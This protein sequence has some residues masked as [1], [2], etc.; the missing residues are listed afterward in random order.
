MLAVGAV[1]A[2]VAGLVY[3][4]EEFVFLAMAVAV[5]LAVGAVSAWHRQRV[6]R[7]GL[8]LVMRVPVAEVGGNQAAV[9]ELTVTNV[10]TGRQPP[11]L[12]EASRG[13]WSVSH[14]GLQESSF[15]GAR[16]S[17]GSGPGAHRQG[18]GSE[19]WLGGGESRPSRRQRAQ[20]RRAVSVARRLPD[21]RPGA[22]VTLSISVPTTRRGLLTLS[23]IG[24]WCEDPFRLVARR[25]TV[26]P[27]A[28]VIVF[29]TPADVTAGRAT[30][31]HPGGHE[32][33]STTGAANALSGDELNGLRP[34]APGDRLTRLHWPSMAR[35][36]DLVVRDFVEPEAGSLSLLVDLRPS[37]H[38]ADSFEPTIARAA[39]YGVRALRTGLTVE[40]CTSTGD[41]VVIA[42]GAAGHQAMLRA[43]ALLGPASPPAAVA[44]RWGNRPTGGA[45]WATA[46]AQGADVV[47]V[48][49]PTGAA[50]RPRPEWLRG[51]AETVL[52]P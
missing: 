34:Y 25:V 6:S 21:L 14:P 38:S 51:Q 49:T 29:P 48:T 35:S 45:V 46:G 17:Q 22:D 42:P 33:S 39:G 30:G 23:G 28:H 37:A 52:V 31:G 16:R 7:R 27:P 19:T 36:G 3:G 44:R 10:G 8:R 15:A 11:V 5:L 9:V 41:R 24:L 13:H 26:A 20:D 47:L 50:Q 32:R 2:A 18:G 1:A 43:L 4:V 12:V 40:L